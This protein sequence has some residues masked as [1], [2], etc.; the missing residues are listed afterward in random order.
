[1]TGPV[2]VTGADGFI[3]SHVV[4]RLVADGHD[5]RAFCVYNSFGSRGWLDRSPV[6]DEVDCVLGDVRDE[7]SV[8]A[9]AAGCRAVIHL[10]AL[11]GIPFS[12]EA[13][14][15]YIDTNIV[16]TTNVL[17]AADAH[18]LDRVVHASTSEVYG[19]PDTT[20][21]RETHPLRAQS[22]YAATKIAAD[23]MVEAWGRSFGTDVVTVRPFNTF[24]PRQSL[25]AVIPTILA[26]LLEHGTVTL[27][28]LR[29]RR[30]FTF[31]TDTA[32]GFVAA[33]DARLD[34]PATVQLGTGRA[35]SIGELV[36]L[37]AD[38]VGVEVETRTDE[39]RI[40]PDGSEVMVLESDPSLARELLDWK[41]TVSLED[42][43]QATADFL[44]EHGSGVDASRYQV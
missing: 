9:A 22:P 34:T 20:P 18:G 28:D 11:I 27:G 39:A 25:R 1:M 33:L 5:V 12:Y 4:E 16:G 17:R 7:D 38:V 42:G 32:A 41:P 30:D 40:R 2:L 10:A 8:R 23:M 21:I 6:G 29:P 3:G 14:R 26:Q 19:T 43:L 35:V 44:A 13:P 31:V 37:C 36:G 24:G 15:S